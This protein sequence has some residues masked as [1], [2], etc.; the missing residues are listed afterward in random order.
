MVLKPVLQFDMEKV[1]GIGGIFFRA[2]D[3]AAL[4]HW[5]RDHLA[6]H[7]FRRTMMSCHGAKKPDPPY[8]RLPRDNRSLWRRR[9]S[10]D[11]QFPRLDAMVEQLRAIGISVELDPQRYPNGR[12]ARLY[13][14]EG[15]LIE[16]WEPEGRDASH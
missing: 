15:N 10:L 16:L 5:R 7:R 14:P 12:F 4:T 2:R 6:S 1:T 13:D 8:L 11:D 9:Q 3:P